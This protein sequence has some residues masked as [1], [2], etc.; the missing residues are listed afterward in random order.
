MALSA[1]SSYYDMTEI[2]TRI[3]PNIVVLTIDPD[4]DVRTK[5]FQ[6]IDHFMKMA[7]QYHEK[8][9]TG[10]T[11]DPAGGGMPLIPGNASLLG[12]AMNSLTS[13]AKAPEHGPVSSM[14]SNI[15]LA[16]ATSNASSVIGNI[17]DVTAIHA[18][19]SIEAPGQPQPS[20]PTSTDGWGELENGALN[21]AHDSDKEGWDDIDSLEEQKPPSLASIQAAQ[22]RPVL[23]PQSQA[24]TSSSRPKATTVKAPKA[25]DDDLWG[26]IAAPAPK[27]AAKSL[28][29]KPASS[30]SDDD[31]WGSIAAPPPRA[32]PR[33]QKKTVVNDDSDPWAAIAAPAP[34]TRA[35]PLALGRGRGGKQTPMKLGAQRIDRTTSS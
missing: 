31:L 30:Q 24:N 29:V 33:P 3:L 25:E 21:E 2:A 10:D 7:K 22:K 15:S 28:N 13:K 16:S 17:P 23:Q 18:S 1:T 26:S 32:A 20:S 5:A 35:K 19:S 12:W 6:A 14:D 8:L 27:T 4:G 9:N 11:S 34:T